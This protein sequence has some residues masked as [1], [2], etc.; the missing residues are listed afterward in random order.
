MPH[1]SLPVL[2]SHLR[3]QGVEVAQHD[4]NIETFNAILSRSYLAHALERLRAQAGARRKPGVQPPV[5][6]LEWALSQGDRLADQVES[7]VA[8]YRSPAF[9]DPDRSEAAY[10]VI[11]DSLELASLPFYPARLDLGGYTAALL[12]DSSQSLL[13]LVRDPRRNMFIDIFKETLLPV[14]EREKPDVIGI[15]IPTMGQMLAGLTLA[16]LVRDARLPAHITVGGPH[17][18]MLREA[19]PRVSQVFSLIDSAV[20]FAGELPL[21]RLADV[22]ASPA[23]DLSQVPGLIYRSGGRV[24]VNPPEPQP[25]RRPLTPDFDGL[26]L[27]K[28][29]VPEPVLPLLTAHGCYH[30]KCAFCNVGYAGTD[31]FYPRSASEVMQEIE[32]L[33]SRYH[34]RHIFF[35]DEA[36]TPRMAREL[37]EQ[38]ENAGTP[39]DWCICVRFDRAFSTDL[40]ER[41]SRAGCRML[42]YG[43]ETASEPVIQRMVKGTHLDQMSRILHDSARAG[44][45]N[46]AFFFFGFPGERMEDAQNT[47]DFVYQHGEQ[48][49]SGS[50]GAFLLERYSPAY[51]HPEQFGIRH[52]RRSSQ[53]DLAIYFDYEVPAGTIDEATADTIA[54]KLVEGLPE[55]PYGQYYEHDAY[56]L[57]YASHLHRNGLPLPPWIPSG[58]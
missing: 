3:Q 12:E 57:L 18:T 4:L 2:A 34:A 52:I 41:M 11:L 56:R 31:G 38:L 39:V 8:V 40:L 33:V 17:I 32:T 55:K 6:S 42:L 14:L 51:L 36:L 7:A 9:Y 5:E 24:V 21:Q 48:I 23:K 28:Y 25:A 26:P 35:A 30:A 29:L 47:V 37:C 13:A 27:A 50:P 44:I 1:L 20:P 19:L 46:H 43:L 58:E 45:W 54:R 53:K 49:H 16:A 15:S 22:L 10:R